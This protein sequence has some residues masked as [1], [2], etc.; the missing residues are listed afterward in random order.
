[1]SDSTALC[2]TQPNGLT[3]PPIDLSALPAKLTKRLWVT[4]TEFLV[5]HSGWGHGRVGRDAA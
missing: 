5:T 4:P 1:M 2:G 3:P